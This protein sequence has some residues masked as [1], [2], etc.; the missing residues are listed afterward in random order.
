MSPIP[1]LKFLLSFYH[2]NHQHQT[3]LTKRYDAISIPASYGRLADSPTPGTVAGIMLGSV[4]GFVFLLYLI[5]LALGS[6]RR[7]S[8]E[9]EMSESVDVGPVR[10]PPSRRVVVEEEEYI[11]RAG[12]HCR[13]RVDGV[14]IDGG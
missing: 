4:V 6:G 2:D 14:G 8:S 9:T 5:F 10:R 11:D 13:R 7:F 3:A 1:A 12:S